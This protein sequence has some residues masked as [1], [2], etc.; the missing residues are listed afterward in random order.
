MCI[1]DR[2]VG[3]VEDVIRAG[4]QACRCVE[5]KRGFREEVQAVKGHQTP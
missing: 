3:E 1:R 2:V 4:V 5:V